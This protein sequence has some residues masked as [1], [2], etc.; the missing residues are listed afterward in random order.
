MRA[1]RGEMGREN[2]GQ[3]GRMELGLTLSNE[4]VSPH[5]T[6]LYTDL[7]TPVYS[8]RS[9]NMLPPELQPLTSKGDRKATS[10]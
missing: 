9:G 6:F 3:R 4:Q 1:L 8:P 2:G 7:V 5:L 10:N